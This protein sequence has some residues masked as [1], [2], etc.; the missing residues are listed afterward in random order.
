MTPTSSANKILLMLSTRCQCNGNYQLLTIYR[1]STNLV[2]GTNFLGSAYNIG[3][4][5]LHVSFGYLDSP[6]TTSSITYQ[7]YFRGNDGNTNWINS[8]D[9]VSGGQS[10]LIAL[11]IKG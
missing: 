4:P 6:S 3:G 11:E 10:T 5:T 8:T 9:T 2:G 7:V 1:D